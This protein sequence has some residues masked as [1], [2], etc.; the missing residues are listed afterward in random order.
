MSEE[1]MKAR[2]RLIVRDKIYSKM[3]QIEALVEKKKIE[4]INLYD[5]VFKT[6]YID[7]CFD[8][9]F[10]ALFHLNKNYYVSPHVLNEFSIEVSKSPMLKNI[11][12][13]DRY[14]GVLRAVFNQFKSSREV[15]RKNKLTQIIKHDFKDANYY[16]NNDF[17]YVVE[18]SN[19]ELNLGH[20][21][22]K[23]IH[24]NILKTCF[25]KDVH[26]ASNYFFPEKIIHP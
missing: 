20:D 14:G 25:L 2:S 17:I 11:K 6:P 26:S 16:Y 22:K 24:A 3:E 15:I 19:I 12:G 13:L 23:N 4:F 21:F 7:Y 8:S 9:R 10:V 1:E 5:D 18:I